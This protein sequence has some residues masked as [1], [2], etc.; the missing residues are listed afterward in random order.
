VGASAVA[1]L[2][3]GIIV[4]VAV[5]SGLL[6]AGCREVAVR[7]ALIIAGLNVVILGILGTR[8]IETHAVRL[9]MPSAQSGP[10][11]IPVMFWL[12]IVGAL[13]VPVVVAYIVGRVA[14]NRANAA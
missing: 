6:L 5:R 7:F 14:R 9:D 8:P 12:F 3:S 11:D 10:P 13:L 1:A 4:A 2:I